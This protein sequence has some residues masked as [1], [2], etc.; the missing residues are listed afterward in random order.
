MGP[1]KDAGFNGLGDATWNERL[2]AVFLVIGIVAIGVAP[3]WL[4]DLLGPGVG[5]IM[6]HVDKAINAGKAVIIK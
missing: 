6:G 2:A 5:T 3:F 4:S 1:V